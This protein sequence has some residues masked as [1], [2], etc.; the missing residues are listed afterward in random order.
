M[1]LQKSH[2]IPLKINPIPNKIDK[3]NVESANTFN[4]ESNAF[5]S[6]TLKTN[7]KCFIIGM[8]AI[9]NKMLASDL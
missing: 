9:K 3:I 5:G 4:C 1:K 8:N 6:F 2:Y 7:C